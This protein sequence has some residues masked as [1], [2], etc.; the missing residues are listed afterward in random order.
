MDSKDWKS[1]LNKLIENDSELQLSEEEKQ[2]ITDKPFRKQ[3]FHIELDKK[4]RNGKQATLISGFEGSEE[5]LK[6]LAAELKKACGVGGSARG[7]EIL[8]QGDFREKVSDLLSRMGHKTK[9]IN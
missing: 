1:Q 4:G 3:S 5:E 8:I 2:S 9:R 7:G 6:N